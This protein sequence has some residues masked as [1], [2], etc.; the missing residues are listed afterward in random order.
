MRKTKRP[1][2][3]NQAKPGPRPGKADGESA[4]LAAIAAMPEP[5]RAMGGR[6]H[7]I[8]KANAP[9]LTPRVWYG[10][11]GYAETARSSA[12]SAVRTSSKRGT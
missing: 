10:M 5:Y 8:I 6:I 3:P 11:P 1:D 12:S 9:A 2:A 7:A 4:V